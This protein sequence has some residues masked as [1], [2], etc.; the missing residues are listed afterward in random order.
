MKKLIIFTLLITALFLSGIQSGSAFEEANAGYESG[1]YRKALEIYLKIAEVTPNWKVFYNIGNS[2]FKLGD[3]VRA[4]ISYLKADRLNPGHL[5]IRQNL[6]IVEEMLNTTIRLPGPDFLG[7]VLMKIERAVTINALS[8]ILIVILL[9]FTFF[10]FRLIRKGRTKRAVYGIIISLILFFSVFFYHS[11][12]INNFRNN[13]IGVVVTPGAQL[14]SGPG[15]GNT[16][17]FEISPGVTVKIIDA[18]RE[19]V[20]VTASPEIAG[21][22][23]VRNIEKIGTE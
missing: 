8:V 2:Y 22:L 4:K 15:T 7:K 17:L 14:R 19:W 21:W 12:R 13:R 23:E 5:S 20:Q 6:D 18:N 3:M 9:V 10:L 11:L 1:E 16:V